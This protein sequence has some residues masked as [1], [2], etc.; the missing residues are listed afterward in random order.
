MFEDR[1]AIE[2]VVGL[3]NIWYLEGQNGLASG[4]TYETVAKRDCRNYL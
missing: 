2:L 3:Q 4:I 1:A